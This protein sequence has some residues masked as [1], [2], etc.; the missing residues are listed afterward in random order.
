[1]ASALWGLAIRVKEARPTSSSREMQIA[2][3]L[4]MVYIWS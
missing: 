4:F 2:L 1:M 3:D